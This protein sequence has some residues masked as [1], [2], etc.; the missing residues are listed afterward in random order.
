MVELAGGM[1]HWVGLT[2]ERTGEWEW[3]NQ[4]PY[5]MNRRWV[6]TLTQVLLS[7]AAFRGLMSVQTA[8]HSLLCSVVPDTGDPVSRTA[9]PSTAWV[10]ET[11]T[12]PTWDMTAAS[13]TCTVPAGCASSARNTASAAEAPAPGSAHRAPTERP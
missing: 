13:T 10:L 12:A 11:R 9:G 1:F 6:V 8:C 5:V 4:T 2:D 3:V 7:T